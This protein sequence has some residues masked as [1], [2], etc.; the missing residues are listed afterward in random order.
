MEQR[1]RTVR[2]VEYHPM[3]R[4]LPSGERPRE[5]LRDRGPG[6]LSNTELLAILL[7]AGTAGENVLDLA[8]RLLSH[9]QG[10]DGLARA[11]HQEL[12]G[13][14]G[15][16]E[17]KAAQLQGP[18]WRWANGSRRCGSRSG[19]RCAHPRTWR[20]CSWPRCRCWT[21]STFAWWF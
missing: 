12:C 17:A 20:T 8:T 7:R 21:R 11:S 9:F 4:D 10:L 3:M 13:V 5:R 18:R 1:R 19:R 14:H 15:L 2:E 16:G 6:S